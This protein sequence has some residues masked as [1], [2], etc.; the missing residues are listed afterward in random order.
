MNEAGGFHHL[1]PALWDDAQV[2]RLLGRAPVA[3]EGGEML[4]FLEG[5][6]VM[7]TGAGGSIG[8][9]LA[10]QIARFRPAGLLLV[11]RAEAALFDVDRKLRESYSSISLI[12]LIADIGDEAR[13]R[14]I[15][16]RH[17]PQVVLHAAAHKH[18]PLME[19]NPVEAMK[20]NTLATNLTGELAAEFSTEVFVLISTDKAV[21]PT[22]VMG[23][24][25]RVAELVAQDLNRRHATRFMAVRFGNVI[26]STG[27]VITI[28]RE[29]IRKGGPVTVTHPDMA[30]YFMTVSEAAQLVLQAGMLGA[31]GE[32]FILDMGEPVKIMDLARDM[33]ILSGLRP[34]ED[35]EIEVTGMR[36]GEKLF[37]ELEITEEAMSKTRHPK[38]FIGRIAAYPPDKV[39][40]ALDKLKSLAIDGR[41]RELRQ[42][43]NELLP[44]ATVTVEP[45][46][47]TEAAAS[48]G[49]SSQAQE[50]RMELTGLTP[51][52]A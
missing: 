5:K 46:A 37:E 52:P 30:R 10:R 40:A 22:S 43:I 4:A 18:V 2:G 44:E 15:F 9:E 29:Q 39:R 20:N 13:M 16:A 50:N 19:L 51:E 17:R 24:S 34:G 45:S 38:I 28:F 26:G 3:L 12:P 6:S 21:R 42:F 25:K 11:E 27:S 35:I 1:N 49:Q 32:I 7:I 14:S 8:S 36:P 23:A 31:G 48:Q 41:E 33:I 47:M